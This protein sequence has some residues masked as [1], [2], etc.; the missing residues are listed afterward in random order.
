MKTFSVASSAPALVLPTRHV[1]KKRLM[2]S[3]LAVLPVAISQMAAADCTST[4]ATQSIHAV[5]DLF[6]PQDA[7]VGSTIGLVKYTRFP[8]INCTTTTPFS[9][10]S[11]MLTA[12]APTVTAAI[13]SA[14]GS[15][16][17]ATNVP[18]IGVGV[19]NETRPSY[20]CLT[21]GSWYFP[22]AFNGCNTGGFSANTNNSL[23]L[24]KTGPI[25]AGI[26][27][28]GN[29]QVYTVDINNNGTPFNWIDGR[30]TGTVTVAGCSMPAAV[31]NI[32][33]VPMKNWE[34]RVFNGPGTVTP[35]EGFN[36][37]LNNCVAGTYAGNPTWNYFRGN[38]ANIR[39]D[40][41]KGSTIVDASQGVLGLNSEA[42]ATG[43]AVQVLK[44]DGTPLPLGVDV[45]IMPVQDGNT[46]LQFGA[47]Y[48]QTAGDSTG[49]QPGIANATANFTI[50]Y[51]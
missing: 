12:K 32:I 15:Q 20:L 21:S 28:F 50:T 19:V 18:G 31:G 11:T 30:L 23:I 34:K 41:A 51:K 24:I 49:P 42:T 36:I 48:I 43:V 27:D 4:D 29:L 5:G 37:A 33:D 9:I 13:G 44:Q 6:I 40:G 3:A 14:Q 16:L 26:N 7:P 39:L 22:L 2:L 47:R 8:I 35:T 25:P 10:Q 45:P 38:N 46:T 17:Y 1:W